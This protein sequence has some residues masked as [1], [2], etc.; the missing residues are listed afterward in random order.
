MCSRH[1]RGARVLP[2]SFAAIPR[3]TCLAASGG[4]LATPTRVGSAG[5]SPV[6]ARVGSAGPCT[7]RVG[8]AGPFGTV[9]RSGA[10]VRSPLR[11]SKTGAVV[12]SP[13][14]P[15]KTVSSSPLSFEASLRI[16]IFSSTDHDFGFLGAVTR[17]WLRA[18]SS[19]RE[20]V[21]CGSPTSCPSR[22]ALSADFPIR[23][24]TIFC[25]NAGENGFVTSSSLS[26]PQGSDLEER[27]NYPGAG[28][29]RVGSP[30]GSGR[31]GSGRV[32]VTP[33]REWRWRS[34]CSRC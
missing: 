22:R 9:G 10:V 28:G 21:V 33:W 29:G 7:T 15:S 19:P 4:R 31:S 25:L 12:R 11:P 1:R 8:S 23:R 20:S 2:I 34:R 17:G 32:A 13:L 3:A 14:R 6:P 30:P 5:P 24:C 16:R 27:D 26:R 18:S